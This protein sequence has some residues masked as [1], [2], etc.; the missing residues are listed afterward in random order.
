[1][2]FLRQDFRQNRNDLRFAGHDALQRRLVGV[3]LHA[4]RFLEG[5]R[6]LA[7]SDR[8][9]VVVDDVRRNEH[10]Q[11]QSF[12]SD[13]RVQR[14][15]DFRLAGEHIV[16]VNGV[17]LSDLDLGRAHGEFLG[18]EADQVGDRLVAEVCSGLQHAQAVA[19]GID[20]GDISEL[21]RRCHILLRAGR[22]L[23]QQGIGDD[24]GQHQAGDFLARRQAVLLEDLQQDRS[25]ASDRLGAV[26]QRRLRLEVGD[27]VMVDDLDDRYFIDIGSALLALVMV[28]KDNLLRLGGDSL[29]K[30]RRADSKVIESVLS[31]AAHRSEADR[32]GVPAELVF[33]V[34]VGDRGANRIRIGVLMAKNKYFFHHRTPSSMNS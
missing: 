25:R 18:V 27:A 8:D 26:V 5:S 29:D 31:L 4:E 23:E 3:Q 16:Q 24:G 10:E 33:Q 9:G 7:E 11:I 32:L 21:A 30:A 14:R 1:M 34:R 28:D 20:A 12:G 13:D 6:V 22:G 17:D 19:G 15:F 2:L